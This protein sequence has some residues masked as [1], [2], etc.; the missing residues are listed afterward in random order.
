MVPN[1]TMRIVSLRFFPPK[2]P[3]SLFYTRV[4]A[5]TPLSP[6]IHF[7]SRSLN[8]SRGLRTQFSYNSSPPGVISDIPILS[9]SLQV[10]T[11]TQ[12]C[13]SQCVSLDGWNGSNCRFMWEPSLWEPLWG[14]Q[15]SLAFTMVSRIPPFKGYGEPGIIWKPE[16]P[17]RE[18]C[19]K[20]RTGSTLYNW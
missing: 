8:S 5:H 9:S 16:F 19:N 15:L 7:P 13:L 6:H 14:L 10:A 1:D 18:R 12:L 2:F 11:S 17:D 4:R 3:L 20:A